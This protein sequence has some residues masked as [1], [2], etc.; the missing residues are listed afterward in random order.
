MAVNTIHEAQDMLETAENISDPVDARSL[1]IC[2]AQKALSDLQPKDD[3]RRMLLE[4][5]ACSLFEQYEDTNKWEDLERATDFLAELIEDTEDS[6]MPTT[7]RLCY[8][9]SRCLQARFMRGRNDTDLENAVEMARESV[10]RTE[11]LNFEDQS[12]LLIERKSHLW[13]CLFTVVHQLEE[14]DPDTMKEM[15]ALAVAV[16]ETLTQEGTVGKPL[17]KALSNLGLSYQ[18]RWD[19]QQQHSDLE[20]SIHLGYQ[21]V[22]LLPAGTDPDARV[23]ALSNLSFRLQRAFLCFVT[24]EQTINHEKTPNGESLQEEAFSTIAESA[25]IDANRKISRIENT[26]SFVAYIKHY[27]KPIRL[28]MLG[29]CYSI[30]ASSMD[31]MQD[32]VNLSLPEDLRDCVTT[33]YGLSRYTA[34][35]ILQAG[36]DPCECLRILEQGREV[37]LSVELEIPDDFADVSLPNSHVQFSKRLFQAKRALRS[38]IIDRVPLHEQK[39]RLKEYRAVLDETVEGSSIPLSASHLDEASIIRLAKDRDIVVVIVTDLRSDAVIVSKG[40]IKIL[41]LPNLDEE[42]LSLLSW[43]IQWRLARESDQEEVYPDLR[44]ALSNMLRDLWNFLV[45]PVLAELG[46]SENVERT[47]P[48][49]RVCWIPTGV[50]SLYPIHA[51]G[52]GLHKKANAMKRVIS[53]YASSLKSLTRWQA[54][55]MLSQSPSHHQ[56][57]AAAAVI[58]SPAGIITMH[59]TPSRISLEFSQQEAAAVLDFFPRSKVLVQPTTAEALSLISGGFPIVHIS[60]HGE[61]DYDFPSNSMLLMKDWK[62]NPLRVT[63][64]CLQHIRS[65]QLVFLSACFTANAGVENLQ[66]EANHLVRALQIAGFPSVI[67]SL[68]YVGQKAALEIVEAFYRCLAASKDQLGPKSISEALHLAVLDF[69]ET[70]R[71]A[72]NKRW[73]DPVLWAPF[74]CFGV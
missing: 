30:L 61:T 59:D 60:C 51:A 67:G 62:E 54:I 15:I 12:T 20:R 18:I 64:I 19:Q 65:S 37:A 34:A 32:V 63:D 24:Q 14:K 70:T 69:G 50:I 17:I 40:K 7:A 1:R 44:D 38:S 49:P 9:F 45:S 43:E 29:R 47:G 25:R 5:L 6:D 46:Y 57:V 22:G 13:L 26:L 66:D 35:A 4:K 52:L 71:T 11:K 27:P 74:V 3:V 72:A 68:W 36:R 33:F 2:V 28:E 16:K 21:V 8:H 23:S 31:T 53:T 48:W 41:S 39:K 56:P 73:G 58:N 55:Q 10:K 42:K